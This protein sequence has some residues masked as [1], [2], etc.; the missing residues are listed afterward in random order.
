MS[1]E[2]LGQRWSPPEAFLEEVT[3]TVE[4][5]GRKANRVPG[6]AQR[7]QATNRS[8]EEGPASCYAGATLT[9]N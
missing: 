1:L 5:E 3:A 7:R 4:A 9:H 8:W 6:R 2:T